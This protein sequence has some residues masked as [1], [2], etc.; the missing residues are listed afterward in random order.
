MGGG[1]QEII[2]KMRTAISAENSMTA[3]VAMYF[4]I[5]FVLLLL[6]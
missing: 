2:K 4:N 5:I 1:G 3:A 6:R